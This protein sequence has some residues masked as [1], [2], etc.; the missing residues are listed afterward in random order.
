M[1]NKITGEMASYIVQLKDDQT[2]IYTLQN[3][4]D[5][6]LEKY[7]IELALSSIRKCYLRNKDIKKGSPI[8]LNEV[9]PKEALKVEKP[10]KADIKKTPLYKTE[11]P[12]NGLRAKTLT[13][14]EINSLKDE[15]KDF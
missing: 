6:V 4:R 7:K 14:D 10:I 9:T 12:N 8:S 11:L 3:I 1:K 13:E 15:L 5:A 2:K